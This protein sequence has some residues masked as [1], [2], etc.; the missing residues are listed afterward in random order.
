[1]VTATSMQNG[2]PF[3]ALTGSKWM[4]ETNAEFVKFHIYLDEAIQLSK[5][6][7]NSCGEAF[8]SKIDMYINFDEM[9]QTMKGEGKLAAYSFPNSAFSKSCHSSFSDV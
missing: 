9:I 3:L 2:L 1:M 8:N 7:V 6:E 5:V 4:P